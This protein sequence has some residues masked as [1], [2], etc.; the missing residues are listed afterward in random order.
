MLETVKPENTP[1]FL[2][3]YD[4]CYQVIDTENHCE[5]V[6]DNIETSAQAEQILEEIKKTSLKP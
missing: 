2:V 6:H 1:R 5:V 4:K 3:V